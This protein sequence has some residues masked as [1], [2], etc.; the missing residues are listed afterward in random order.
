MDTTAPKM[1]TITLTDRPPVSIREDLWPVIARGNRHDGREF[2][3]QANRTWDVRVRQHQDGRMVVYGTY[4]T[5]W[6][7]ERDMRAGVLLDADADVVA[8]I[9]EVVEQI[10]G[11]DGLAQDCIADLPA[12]EI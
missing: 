8:A 2:A 5:N 12:E 9:R 6:Q 7:G 1:R 4:A 3:S 11:S 10:G